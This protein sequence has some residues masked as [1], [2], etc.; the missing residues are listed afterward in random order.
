M[1]EFK[2]IIHTFPVIN[3]SV[4][5]LEIWLL[6]AEEYQHATLGLSGDHRYLVASLNS[7]SSSM[8]RLG[9]RLLPGFNEP[10]TDS[11]AHCPAISPSEEPEIPL[12]ES[13]SFAEVEGNVAAFLGIKV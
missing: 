11:G 9:S 6:V 4:T 7:S 2:T 3:I 13:F 1:E 8:A 5:P 12:L 10:N